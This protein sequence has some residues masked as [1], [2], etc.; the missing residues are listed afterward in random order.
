MVRVE[1][2]RE[3]PGNY[4]ALKRNDPSYDNDSALTALI[5]AGAD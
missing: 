3:T 1:F 2:R 5:R 4:P